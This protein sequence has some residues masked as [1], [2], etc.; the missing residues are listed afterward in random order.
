MTS[1]IT[2]LNNYFQ[3]QKSSHVVSYSESSQGPSHDI[4]WTV[5]CKVSGVVKGTGV[6]SSKNAAKEEAAKQAL[7]TYGL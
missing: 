6:A 5:Q 3:G 7:A 2:Q 4:K 1:Y